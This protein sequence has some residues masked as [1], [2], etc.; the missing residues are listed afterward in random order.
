M[1]G[2]KLSL[3]G[4]VRAWLNGQPIAR[5]RSNRVQ[6]LLVYLATETAAGQSS[7]AREML[8]DLLWPSLPQKSA[9][10][11]L[12][13]TLYQLRQAVPELA[14]DG[15]G[16]PVS[17]LLTDR[18]T[19][20]L[21]SAYP[22]SLDVTAFLR[23]LQVSS[24]EQAEAVT[25]YRGDFLQDFYLPDAETFE[26]WAAARR[27]A[28]RREVL[29]VLSSLS[30]HSIE[31]HEY[32]DAERYA[33]RQLE[34]DNLREGAHRQLMEALALSGR[35]AGAL[36]HFD[37]LV[38]LLEQELEVA[39]SQQ[40]MATLDAIRGEELQA[41]S[42]DEATEVRT[43]VPTSP[44]HNL[45]TQP[46][47]FV[48]RETE[49]AA[50]DS[51]LVDPDI[52]LITLTGPGGIGKTRLALAAAERLLEAS[53]ADEMPFPDGIYFVSL[54]PLNDVERIA[55]AIAVALGFRFR[56]GE[57]NLSARQQLMAYL[58]RRC[59]LLI[60]DNFEHLLNG[61]ELVADIRQHAPRV[62]ILATSRERLQLQGEQQI[63]LDGLAL[64]EEE[65]RPGDGTASV[66]LFLQTARHLQPAFEVIGKQEQNQL[67][68]IC[69]LVHGVPLAIELAAAWTSTLSL[70]DIVVEIQQSLD[71]LAVEWRDA[72]ERHHSMRALF[73]STWKQLGTEGRGV[74]A[75]LSVFRGGFSREAAQ[76]VAGASLPLLARLVSK[77][78]LQFQRDTDRYQV[79]E[80]LRW[81]AAGKLGE[82]KEM[83]ATIRDRHSAYYCAFL[84]EQGEELKGARQLA[85]ASEIETEL[86]NCRAAWERAIKHRDI[87]NLALALDGLGRFLLD[88]RGRYQEAET[89]FHRAANIAFEPE[90]LEERQF[91][92]RVLS[93]LVACQEMQGRHEE[94]NRLSQRCLE[95]L[96]DSA[97]DELEDWGT[98]AHVLLRLAHQ[99][100]YAQDQIDRLQLA[101]RSLAL[102]RENV[103]RWG[104]A[105]ALNV[106]GRQIHFLWR[107]EEAER[108]G[109]E[110][111]AIN[112]ELG[113]RRGIA[114]NLLWLGS[115]ALS[116]PMR[117]DEAEALMLEGLALARDIN[118]RPGESHFLES[119]SWVYSGSGRYEQA[120]AVD[121]KSL[122]IR[123][124]RGLQHGV[125]HSW[126]QLAHTHMHMGQY[127]EA[128]ALA[129]K[130]RQL[131]Q[132]IGS[133]VPLY[134]SLRVLGCLAL[135]KAGF[136]EAERL[137][138][139]A[140]EIIRSFGRG[141]Q[142]GVLA[143]TL[144]YLSLAVLR[145][146]RFTQARQHMLEALTIAQQLSLRINILAFA[147]LL[148]IEEGQTER[149][150]ELF[151]LACTQ[152]LIADSRWFDDVVGR[153]I[154]AA[155]ETLST[156]V[157]AEARNRG[158]TMD[159]WQ[160]IED[161]LDQLRASE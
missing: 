7:F 82:D 109:R 61:A 56:E 27:G 118:D 79:H 38:R 125:A 110:S 69:R 97:I 142:P 120:L 12:R 108:L 103:D 102:F 133:D 9:Q 124:E 129:E 87:D 148:L 111:M 91:L 48:G 67:R 123:Q 147:A 76:A 152:P 52:R 51:F 159:W 84:E 66:A 106:L 140:V 65:G 30:E 92:I 139:Q 144:C 141:G 98:K 53:E 145:L 28:Y 14:L 78:L 13:T 128:H 17:L 107:P 136:A 117:Y 89:L 131:A 119:L 46:T 4:S 54:A 50:L 81:Y 47:P 40:T 49:L 138:Q 157:A 150:L 88:W 62:Q 45:P 2:L 130:S 161:L 19:V 94:S 126:F 16:E 55:P 68:Q 57:E 93:W 34:I 20:W 44:P 121:Y 8:M 112:R 42:P 6:A 154:E 10:T 132:E 105:A 95:L 37:T 33:R 90:M 134:R 116:D 143:I 43:S 21:N 60:L 80:L 146:G 15:D 135:A 22:L 1:D 155:A 86:D 85:A 104:E 83:E 127:E 26:E 137:L 99:P 151:A 158:E 5:F 77:S 114:D 35:R 160:T 29:D 73:E 23:G 71:F 72:P 18:K 64:A 74:F 11:N 115:V 32:R 156:E 153:H 36:A 101:E 24:E 113:N 59:L 25:L 58:K 70:E 41:S 122:L 3:L 100:A 63:S 39:P 75:S 149:G 31:N 96:E